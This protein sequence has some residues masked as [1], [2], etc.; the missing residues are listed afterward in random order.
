MGD[1]EKQNGSCSVKRVRKEEMKAVRLMGKVCLLPGYMLKS[2]L[3]YAK[4]HVL[5]HVP[6]VTGVFVEV[7]DSSC[8]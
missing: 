7:C 1:K 8:H 3:Q 2:V 6:D 4:G 5:V